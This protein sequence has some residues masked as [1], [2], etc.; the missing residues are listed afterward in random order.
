MPCLQL[1]SPPPA[2]PSSRSFSPALLT[3]CL[4]SVAPSAGPNIQSS[5]FDAS[6]REELTRTADAKVKQVSH[7]RVQSSVWPVEGAVSD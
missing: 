3:S 6:G 1:L 4:V 5:L 2:L 7:E